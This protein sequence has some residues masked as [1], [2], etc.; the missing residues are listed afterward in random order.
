MVRRRSR[1]VKRRYVIIAVEFV[2]I[3]IWWY[4]DS[5]MQQRAVM[6]DATRLQLYD[7]LS[8]HAITAIVALPLFFV[9]YNFIPHIPRFA[10]CPVSIRAAT[11]SVAAIVI[12]SLVWCVLNWPIRPPGLL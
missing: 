2:L 12:Y 5:K 6:F 8:C 4:S 9:S 1:I 7:L 10:A 11:M 3:A